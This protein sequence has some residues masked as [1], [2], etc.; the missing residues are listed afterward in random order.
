MDKP[1]F[2]QECAFALITKYSPR[3]GFKYWYLNIQYRSLQINYTYVASMTVFCHITVL[4]N[5]REL[6]TRM[7][8]SDALHYCPTK[9]SDA[10]FDI[11][12][13]LGSEKRLDKM[14]I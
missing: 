5:Q 7:F 3:I 6:L 10:F 4:Q 8:H 9:M 12:Q 13:A 2:I 14:S 1:Q 11:H